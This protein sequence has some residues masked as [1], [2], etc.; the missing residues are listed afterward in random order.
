M[1]RGFGMA[2]L[3]GFP[4]VAHKPEGGEGGSTGQQGGE[5]GQGQGQQGGQG[6]GTGTGQQGGTGGGSQGGPDDGNMNFNDAQQRWLE[7]KFNEAY[8]KGAEKAETTLKSQIEL[9]NAEVSK[10]K[11]VKKPNE[12]GKGDGEGDK[13]Y[14][15][16]DLKRL[17][18]EQ[19]TEYDSK[20]EAASKRANDL[21]AKDRQAAIIAA[22]AKANVA[23]DYREFSKLVIDYIVHDDKGNLVVS[24]DGQTAKLN[25]KGEPTTVDDFVKTY[26]DAR[27]HLKKGTGTAGAGSSNAGGNAGGALAQGGKPRTVAEAN[28]LLA[29][30][31]RGGK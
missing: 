26:V 6:Q 2:R 22:A 30:A 24:E 7:K 9:L 18:D 16:I 29:K 5:G 23:G 13:T 11:G 28:A 17:L 19:A 8:R 3:A 12:T 4:M 27:P 15:Q 25:S 20:L 31:F 1:L 21:L 14:T 10:L